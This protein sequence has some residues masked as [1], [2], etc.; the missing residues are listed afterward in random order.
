MCGY[1]RVQADL[2][3]EKRAAVNLSQV[4]PNARPGQPDEKRAGNP[5]RRPLSCFE[6]CP[7]LAAHWAAVL[8]RASIHAGAHGATGCGACRS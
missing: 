8:A 7:Y 3:H 1:F 5:E 2:S 4:L 6:Y